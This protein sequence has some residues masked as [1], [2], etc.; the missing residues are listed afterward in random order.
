MAGARFPPVSACFPHRGRGKRLANSARVR[1]VLIA[2]AIAIAA[3]ACGGG[4]SSPS[5]PSPSYPGLSLTIETAHYVFHYAD[6][7]RVESDRQEAFHDWIAPAFGVALPAKIDFFKY[8]SVGHMQALTGRAANGLAD[9]PANA[10]HSIFSWH[11]H[12]SVHIYSALVGRPSDF[13]NEGIAVALAV[14][15]LGGRDYPLWSSTP[16]H[17]V[18]RASLRSGDVPPLAAIVETS[19]FRALPDS[20]S[21]PAAGSF[22][23][24]LVDTRGL[25]AVLAFFRTGDRFDSLETIERNFQA[26]FGVTL[27]EADAAWRAFLG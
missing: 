25:A 19:P 16:V 27:A 21:Y 12:E 3:A 18:A 14:D 13:F 5:A 26:A 1:R 8:L 20:V 9:V 7:D 24:F 17:D 11:A 22:M 4:S 10:I 6:G 23:E 15:P 2:L